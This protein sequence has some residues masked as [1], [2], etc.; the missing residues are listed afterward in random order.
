MEVSGQLHTLASLPPRKE[1]LTVG[2]RLIGGQSW[3]GCGGEEKNCQPLPG[4]KPPIIQPV[5]QCY[6]T[7]LS[8]LPLLINYLNLKLVPF[9]IPL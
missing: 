3:S 2:R 7:E 8:Q 6:T 1:I 9:P 4:H 5:A